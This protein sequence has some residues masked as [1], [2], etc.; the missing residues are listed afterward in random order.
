MEELVSDED[1]ELA[2]YL[3][4]FLSS[5]IPLFDYFSQNSALKEYQE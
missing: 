5:I 3:D 4:Y 2:N 1:F